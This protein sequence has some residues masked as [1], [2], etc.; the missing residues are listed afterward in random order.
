MATFCHIPGKLPVCQCTQPVQQHWQTQCQKE[1][2]IAFFGAT[3]L[4]EQNL[5]S[6][7]CN[8]GIGGYSLPVGGSNNLIVTSDVA[9]LAGK[10][11]QR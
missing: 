9:M 11:W 2:A 1:E 7:V 6:V 3:A 4:K 10:S 8:A 5:A